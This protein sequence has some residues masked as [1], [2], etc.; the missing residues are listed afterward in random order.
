M[1]LARPEDRR[2]KTGI[3]QLAVISSSGSGLAIRPSLLGVVPLTAIDESIPNV[4][5]LSLSDRNTSLSNLRSRSLDSF[6]STGSEGRST[7]LNDSLSDGPHH[8]H[9]FSDASNLSHPDEHQVQLDTNR[10]FIL[11]PVGKHV[12]SCFFQHSL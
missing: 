6:T 10:S 3:C 12:R 5:E 8:S 9:T 1:G 11:Y 2:G 7:Y 4:E